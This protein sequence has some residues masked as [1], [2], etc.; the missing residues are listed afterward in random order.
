MEIADKTGTDQAALFMAFIDE[1]GPVGLRALDKGQERATTKTG[2]RRH[3][4]KNG[5]PG[6]FLETDI[7]PFY[8]LRPAPGAGVCRKTLPDLFIRFCGA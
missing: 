6:N 8:A 7:P 3:P 5:I 4:R 2:A 1:T